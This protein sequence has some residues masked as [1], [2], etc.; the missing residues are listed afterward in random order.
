[1]LSL[2]GFIQEYLPLYFYNRVKIDG[3][4]LKIMI[5]CAPIGQLHVCGLKTIKD[6][7][8]LQRVFGTLISGEMSS[9]HSASSIASSSATSGSNFLTMRTHHRKMTVPCPCSILTTVWSQSQRT[10]RASEGAVLTVVPLKRCQIPLSPQI[11]R[12]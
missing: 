1:M 2:N 9:R 7:M 3:E 12:R 4:A 11:K 5:N 10:T 8:K 6:Q